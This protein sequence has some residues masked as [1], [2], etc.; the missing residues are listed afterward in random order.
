[1]KY[2]LEKLVYVKDFLGNSHFVIPNHI[3]T[4]IN[5]IIKCNYKGVLTSCD[6]I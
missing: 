3:G 2:D 1:M 4:L 5:P 6:K